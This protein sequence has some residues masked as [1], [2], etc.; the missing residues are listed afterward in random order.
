MKQKVMFLV[1][2]LLVL[3]V[4]GCRPCPPCP[5][6]PTPAVPTATPTVVPTA[7]P[8][9]ILWDSKLSE[10]GV[11][12]QFVSGAKYRLISAWT[13]ENGS[14]DN[15]PDWARQYQLDTLGGDHHV[16]GRCLDVNGNA[17]G[18]TFML[19]WPDGAD[20]RTPE[21][22]GWANLPL[23]GQNWNPANGQGPYK[24]EALD[25]DKLVG[26]GL[27]LNHHWSFFGV[28]KEVPRVTILD[29]I[30]NFLWG[31]Q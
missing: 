20:G 1:L 31:N 13:T 30:M 3:L 27:P 8:Q 11:T 18:K 4:T 9:T 10:L 23:G 26:L 28:W 29:T 12:V 15:V 22:D 17:I 19:S 5:E 14:W 21:Q 25:G 7:T 24:W 2:V 16:F 6:C